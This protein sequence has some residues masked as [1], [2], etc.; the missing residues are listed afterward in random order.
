MGEKTGTVWTVEVVKRPGQGLGLYLRDGGDR[1]DGVFVS[2]VVPGSVADLNGSLAVGDEILAVDGVSVA[3]RELEDV[4]VSMS[5]PRRLVLNVRRTRFPAAP[6][7]DAS[8]GSTPVVVVKRGG[9]VYADRPRSYCC[10]PSYPAAGTVRSP[11]RFLF[12]G[13][14]RGIY[15]RSLSVDFRRLEDRSEDI[16]DHLRAIP[17]DDSGDSGLSSDNS[18]MSRLTLEP[19]RQIRTAVQKPLTS[20]PDSSSANLAASLLMVKSNTSSPHF[21]R[22]TVPLNPAFRKS[23]EYFGTLSDSDV[24]YARNSRG[25]SVCQRISTDASFSG[26]Q[27]NV[28]P[29]RTSS[30]PCHSAGKL[31]KRTDFD[32]GQCCR[33]VSDY[34]QNSWYSGCKIQD[35]DICQRH[36]PDEFLI[37]STSLP[38]C[39]SDLTWQQNRLSRS[40]VLSGNCRRPNIDAHGEI[41]YIL[42]FLFTL[43]IV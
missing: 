29:D 33:S 41:L 10:S 18:G 22:R 43:L 2:R 11:E 13:A 3:G 7:E 23:E 9:S 19:V 32:A 34:S 26:M 40:P 36:F 27:S 39:D 8:Q 28:F 15:P 17:A 16:F 5:I 38:R 21:G 25:V 35:S 12:A 24:M 20:F 14:S 4:V 6:L 42:K 37:P 31:S 1:S 30:S